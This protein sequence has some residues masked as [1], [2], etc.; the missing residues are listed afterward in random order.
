MEKQITEKS[1]KKAKY[2]ANLLLA[3]I[4]QKKIAKLLNTTKHSI[5]NYQRIAQKLN[6]LPDNSEIKHYALVQDVHFQKLKLLEYLNFEWKTISNTLYISEKTIWVLRH[7]NRENVGDN[8]GII[9]QL[10]KDIPEHNLCVNDTIIIK[11]FIDNNEY[12]I[13]HKRINELADWESKEFVNC[14][15]EELIGKLSIISC[16]PILF[17]FYVMKNTKIHS[18]PL[19]GEYS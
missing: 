15:P 4:N 18:N 7:S 11:S 1:K 13:R 3:G 9:F 17:N 19:L 2:I 8:S 6:Y 5:A 16:Y 12:V 10:T 14:K